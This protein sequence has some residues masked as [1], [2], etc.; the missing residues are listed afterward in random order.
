MKEKR[1]ENKKHKSS[2]DDINY[3]RM[4][5]EEESAHGERG[6]ETKHKEASASKKIVDR[7]RR[8]YP[9]GPGGSYD[10]F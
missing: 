6:K 10:G 4:S 1:E 8:G 2:D 3:G 9:D 7:V 5:G